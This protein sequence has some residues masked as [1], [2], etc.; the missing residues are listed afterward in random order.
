MVPE[1]VHTRLPWA[2]RRRPMT[3]GFDALDFV[4][5][6]VLAH[7]RLDHVRTMSRGMWR[8]LPDRIGHFDPAG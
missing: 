1:L 6:A 3:I 4:L 2:S 8:R 7:P 5:Y